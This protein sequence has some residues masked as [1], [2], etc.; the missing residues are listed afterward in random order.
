MFYSLKRVRRYG[1]W[2]DNCGFGEFLNV[3]DNV[4]CSMVLLFSNLLGNCP[5]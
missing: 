4:L 3:K 1:S 2:E 5:K